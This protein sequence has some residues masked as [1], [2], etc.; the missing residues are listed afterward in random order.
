MLLRQGLEILKDL[1][2]YKMFSISGK[3]FFVKCVAKTIQRK[4]TIFRELLE[5]KVLWLLKGLGPL[6]T[7]FP[8]W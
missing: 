7:N 8:P 2:V 6:R 1:I 5:S 3:Y 4:Y